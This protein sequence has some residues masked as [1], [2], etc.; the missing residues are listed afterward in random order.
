MTTALVKN[1]T[2]VRCV[3]DSDAPVIVDCGRTLVASPGTMAGW[4]TSVGDDIYALFPAEYMDTQPDFQVDV[5]RTF[6]IEGGLVK[7]TRAWEKI[8]VSVP[9]QI[10]NAQARIWLR[11]NGFLAS[12]SA[13]IQAAGEEASDRWDWGN[14]FE[15]NHPMTLAISSVI[16][17]EVGKTDAE[18]TELMNRMFIEASAL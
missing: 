2:D 17:S 7:I 1:G 11:R 9:Q 16:Q 18:M 14:F 15:R 10:T 12:V 3:Y 4:S 8:Q 6:A 13:A 5:G